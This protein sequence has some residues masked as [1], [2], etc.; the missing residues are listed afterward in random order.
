VVGAGPAGATAALVL[1]RAG[2]RVLLVDRVSFP[3]DKACGDLV[4]PRAVRLLEELEV[5]MPP[6]A[7]AADM[8]LA[9]PRRGLVDLPWPASGAF[10]AYALAAPRLHFDEALYR[11]ALTAGAE[12]LQGTVSGLTREG[13]RVR[14]ELADGSQILADFVIAADGSLG[15]LGELAGLSEPS[16]ALYGFALRYYADVAVE[17]PLIVYT[18]PSP[19]VPYPGYGWLFPGPGDRANI[20]LGIAVGN[21]RRVSELATRLVEPFLARLKR[22][23]FVP[24]DLELEQ[25]RGAFL[26]MGLAGVTPAGGQVFLTGDACA[27]VNPLQGEGIAEGMLSGRRAAELILSAPA[28]AE[29]DY[30]RFIAA[31]FGP[32]YSRTIA[33]QELFTAHQRLFVAVGGL[34]TSRHLGQSLGPGWASYWNDLTSETES[35]RP[36]LLARGV[37]GIVGALT[38][39][40]ARRQEIM[41]KLSS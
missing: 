29:D 39:K 5:E 25:R 22:M 3:R 1:A 31:R 11:A 24:A 40:S 6:M 12:P 36:R 8:L 2:Q 30:R 14:L 37:S 9:G 17:R 18:E 13:G 27:L 10:P 23:G 19:E 38:Y 16:R 33:A 15:R 20:G 4:G 32:F 41:N 21:D 26:R 34:M 7:V 35:R 28:S